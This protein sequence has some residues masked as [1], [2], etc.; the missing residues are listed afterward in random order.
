MKKILKLRSKWILITGASSGLGREIARQ[1]AITYQANLILVA[2]RTEQLLALKNELEK[3]SS[4]QCITITA[5]LTIENDLKRIYKISTQNRNLDGVILNAG[6]TCFNKHCD[7]PPQ[8]I[9]QI[10]ATNI[11]SVIQLSSL[12]I[13][14]LVKQQQ[15]GSLVMISSMAGLVPLPYQA[16]YSGSKAFL[17]SYGECLHQELKGEN[18]SVTILAPGGLNTEMSEKNGLAR[19][20]AGTLQMQSATLCAKQ[21]IHAMIHRKVLYIP[22]FFNQFQ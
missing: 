19:H 1:L 7:I 20:F 9:K 11:D 15:P 18:L 8:K 12:F 10:L 4:S 5:D 21:T 2:R 22:G 16:V 13:P 14:H 3:S 17:I 6:I